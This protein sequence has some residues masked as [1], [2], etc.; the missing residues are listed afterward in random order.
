MR[1]QA[2]FQPLE[3]TVLAAGTIDLAQQSGDLELAER[4]VPDI[5]HDEV[6]VERVLGTGEQLDRLDGLERG[7]H[8]DRGA[9]HAGCLA[10]R[11]HAG[12]R[13]RL[14]QAAKARRLARDD[15]HRLALAADHAAVRP[16]ACPA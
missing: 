16:R 8:R 2:A 9:E 14:D 7:D 10:G 12:R 11:G 15:R 6:A 1:A 5:D 13:G 4:P 3:P